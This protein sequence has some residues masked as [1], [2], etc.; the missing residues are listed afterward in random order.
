MYTQ[1]LRHLAWQHL[2]RDLGRFGSTMLLALDQNRDSLTVQPTHLV[3]TTVAT[4][5]MQE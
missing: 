3:A 4:L 5:R 2:V 1:E